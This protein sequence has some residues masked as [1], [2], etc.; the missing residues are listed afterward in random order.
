MICFGAQRTRKC[1]NESSVEPQKEQMGEDTIVNLNK[2][3]FEGIHFENARK[4][5]VRACGYMMVRQNAF[6]SKLCSTHL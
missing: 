2:T 6:F 4:K 1:L 3:S 5:I